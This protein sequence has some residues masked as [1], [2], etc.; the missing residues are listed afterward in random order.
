MSGSDHTF[1]QPESGVPGPHPHTID[2]QPDEEQPRRRR[3]RPR[4]S[5]RALITDATRTH[6]QD[7]QSR[8]KQYLLW[9]GARVPLIAI[10]VLCAMLGHWWFAALFFSISIPVPWI[11]VMIANG[12]GEAR[13]KRDKNVYKPAL[14]REEA[15][16]AA[17]ARAQ[18]E[19]GQSRSGA[20]RSPTIIE[21]DPDA[22]KE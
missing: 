17:Q 10:S 9:Q 21:S 15:R 4:R 18:L 19:A 11:S 1:H 5:R 3:L 12:Q 22:S 16:L 14:A 6:E 13:D 2:A 7:L 8:E 20:D